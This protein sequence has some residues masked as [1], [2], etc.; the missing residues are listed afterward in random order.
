MWGEESDGIYQKAG[1]YLYRHDL[2]IRVKQKFLLEDN[3]QVDFMVFVVAGRM[4][5]GNKD[6]L[7]AGFRKSWSF[8]ISTQGQAPRKKRG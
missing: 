8:Y 5:A 7:E 4:R 1:C 2:H 6:D 3:S